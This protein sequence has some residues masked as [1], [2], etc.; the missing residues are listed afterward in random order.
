M[1]KEKEVLEIN[2]KEYAVV[3]V[4]NEYAYLINTDNFN[5]VL[6]VK[7]YDCE[8]EVI[9]SKNLLNKIIKMF[10]EIINKKKLSEN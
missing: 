2:N 5:D 7:V 9:N 3:S 1:I 10:N 8:V 6:F 4:H